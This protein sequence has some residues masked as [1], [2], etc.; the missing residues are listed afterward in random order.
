M[1]Y[2]VIDASV[3]LKWFFKKEP[4]A[5]Q[6]LKLLKDIKIKKVKPILPTLWIYEVVNGF[7]SAILKKRIKREE[8]EY[9]VGKLLEFNFDSVDMSVL[10]EK[11]IKNSADYNFSVYDSSYITLAK[12]R[13]CAFYTG[14]KKLYNKVKGKVDFV[15]WIGEL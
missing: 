11:V 15:K 6:A 12:D 5:I 1:Q 13:K 9:F 10:M 7:Y 14:D 3:I 8:A 4:E 2:L